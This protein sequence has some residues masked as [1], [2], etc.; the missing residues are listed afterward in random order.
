MTLNRIEDNLKAFLLNPMRAWPKKTP[1]ISNYKDESIY[2]RKKEGVKISTGEVE[3][4][5]NPTLGG[6]NTTFKNIGISLLFF[7]R[8]RKKE[9]PFIENQRNI[10]GFFD[11][12]RNNYFE[13][14]QLV[15]L[16]KHNNDWQ[17]TP[18]S[19]HSDHYGIYGDTQDPDLNKELSYYGYLVEN[20]TGN[21]FLY[22]LNEVW[23]ILNLSTHLVFLVGRLTD[24]FAEV[25]HGGDTYFY[26]YV[27]TQIFDGSQFIKIESAEIN[28]NE[29][30]QNYGDLVMSEITLMIMDYGETKEVED[31]P[32][33]EIPINPSHNYS[34][35]VY[36]DK[37]LIAATSTDSTFTEAEWRTGTKT[38]NSLQLQFRPTTTST[39]RGIAYSRDRISDIQQQNNPFTGFFGSAY[40][41]NGIIS[42]DDVYYYSYKTRNSYF[43]VPVTHQYTITPDDDRD[44][45]VVDYLAGDSGKTHTPDDFS[46]SNSEITVDPERNYYEL[47][48]NANPRS[49]LAIGFSGQIQRIMSG[50]ENLRHLFSP[51]I[52]QPF[53]QKVIRGK[54]FNIFISNITFFTFGSIRLYY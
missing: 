37:F 3:Y 11:D 46:F 12:E 24:E 35:V 23:K 8:D 16:K 31:K 41:Y 52:D 25:Y 19:N 32:V 1:I 29:E 18:I 5:Q 28:Y 17:A 38:T 30:E 9:A 42:V 36:D 26:S 40:V 7:D 33:F 2:K 50:T 44:S 4:I 54:I 48:L 53:I 21:H 10:T 22:R 6:N 15:E 49:Y 47:A 43:P 20:E 14:A 45:F 39:Y 51:S 27:P 34:P 13:V